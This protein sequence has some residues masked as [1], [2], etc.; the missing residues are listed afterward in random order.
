MK[1]KLKTGQTAWSSLEKLQGQKK[2]KDGEGTDKLRHTKKGQRTKNGI[3]LT[4]TCMSTS[5]V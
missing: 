1:I 5:M 3:L 2:K 4:Y